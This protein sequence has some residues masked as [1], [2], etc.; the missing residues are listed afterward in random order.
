MMRLRRRGAGAGAAVLPPR[1]RRVWV[2][3]RP[4]WGVMLPQSAKLARQTT[5]VWHTEDSHTLGVR[6]LNRLHESR[7]H[8]ATRDEPQS[9]GAISRLRNPAQ[10]R[11]E[12]KQRIRPPM[13]GAED[14]PGSQNRGANP[15][16]SDE[17]FAL[18]ANGDIRVHHRSGM[19]N[20]DVDKM[21][22]SS[23]PRG[24]DRGVNRGEIDSP[25][26]FCLRW[27]WMRRANEMNERRA[28][29]DGARECVRVQRVT[30]HRHGRLTAACGLTLVERARARCGFA[31]ATPQ[32]VAGQ[33]NRCHR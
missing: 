29:W 2:R 33:R 11:V 12:R 32:S 5:N 4:A 9:L 6:N 21:I 27:V 8:R 7:D 24:C 10:E 28:R 14:V 25:E 16:C 3:G 18:L 1:V 17:R 26:F 19:R 15:C 30:N 23:L 22:D 13:P 31:R 20:A